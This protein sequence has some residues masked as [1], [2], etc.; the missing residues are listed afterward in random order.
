MLEMN[1]DR[2]HN[3]QYHQK[4]IAT[5]NQYPFF[6]LRGQAENVFLFKEGRSTTRFTNT[7][8]PIYLT[9]TGYVYG[10]LY[11]NAEGK[12]LSNGYLSYQRQQENILCSSGSLLKY[13]KYRLIAE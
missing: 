10:D 7:V 3:T 5:L 8:H 4:V 13:I 9:T 1:D 12:I 11:L 2:F 6:G